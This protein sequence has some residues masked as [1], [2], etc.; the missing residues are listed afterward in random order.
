MKEN[1]ET[2]ATEITRRYEE[3]KAC[4]Q[5]TDI[6]DQNNLDEVGNDFRLMLSE[7]GISDG[8]IENI[9]RVIKIEL[10]KIAD[11]NAEWLHEAIF[12]KK[13]EG[14]NKE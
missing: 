11:R 14:E 5:L 6:T 8:N 4:T 10:N 2:K 7:L 1:F 3:Y 13:K 12:G 9:F